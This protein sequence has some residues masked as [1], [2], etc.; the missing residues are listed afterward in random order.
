LPWA[1]E[2]LYLMVTTVSFSI[3][4]GPHF[5]WKPKGAAG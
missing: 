1:S 5:Q 3:F 4:M 2:T